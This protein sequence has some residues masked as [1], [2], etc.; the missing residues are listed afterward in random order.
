MF[1]IFTY[2]KIVS[3]LVKVFQTGDRSFCLP[4]LIAL[5]FFFAKLVLVLSI[6]SLPRSR[7]LSHYNLHGLLIIY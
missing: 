5:A 2:T 4:K 6:L 3:N 7:S 1:K